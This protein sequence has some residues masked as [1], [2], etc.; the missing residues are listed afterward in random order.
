MAAAD[1]VATSDLR[2]R[3]TARAAS[4]VTG[5][6]LAAGL[7]MRT[8]S[9]SSWVPKA[10]LPVAGHPLLSRQLSVMQSA[11]IE[12]LVIVVGHL[13]ESVLDYLDTVRPSGL[14]IR[15]R[16]QEQP[17]GIGHALALLEPEL[18]GPFVLLL[19]D[20]FFLPTR[21]EEL[22]QPVLDGTC[23]AVLAVCD[24]T[25]ALRMSRNFQVWTS[26]DGLVSHVLEKPT[27][28]ACGVKGCGLYAFN[29]ELF[30]AIRATAP[31][32][33]GELG[34]TEAITTLIRQG[35]RVSARCVTR[36]DMNITTEADLAVCD[37]YLAFSDEGR[38]E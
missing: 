30:P 3:A 15:T 22:W 33:N 19:G 6:I 14:R 4:G 31:G 13:R 36:W 32:A 34:L 25:D 38:R 17:R 35:R 5:V 18:S 23:D 9:L 20:I 2:V 16:V 26:A 37:A 28:V 29:S 7:G 1:G 11:G 21:L 24:E 10:L 12:D 8:G 27:N